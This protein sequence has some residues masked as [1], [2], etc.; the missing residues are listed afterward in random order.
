MISRCPG[1]R[2]VTPDLVSGIPGNAGPGLQS[3]S[4]VTSGTLVDRAN[5]LLYRNGG[6]MGL[7]LQADGT[8]TP[9]D[10]IEAT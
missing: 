1:Y 9:V 4:T 8:A 2:A 3:L 6:D 7:N 5:T 10:F